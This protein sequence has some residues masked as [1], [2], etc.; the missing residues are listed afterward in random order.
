[1]SSWL[2]KYITIEA[3]DGRDPSDGRVQS[4]IFRREFPDGHLPAARIPVLRRND[5]RSLQ[6]EE[7]RMDAMWMQAAPKGHGYGTY[8]YPSLAVFR[9][10]IQLE[11]Y[12]VVFEEIGTGIVVDF[13]LV[14]DVWFSRNRDGC[15]V[16]SSI[17]L[18][19]VF[20][21]HGVGKDAIGLEVRLLKEPGYTALPNDT[22]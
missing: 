18:N 21:V 19:E 3:R 6:G 10:L 12:C 9:K 11:E 5:G 8:E 22:F 7:E 16:E 2:C 4:R 20:R 17:I 14:G 15:I 13:V 1:M